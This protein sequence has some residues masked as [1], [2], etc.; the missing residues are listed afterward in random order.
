MFSK[1]FF[2]FLRGIKDR[3]CAINGNRLTISAQVYDNGSYFSL[4][5]FSP[6]RKERKCIYF[7][8]LES[9]SIA[10]F[11]MYIKIYGI[12]LKSKRNSFVHPFFV[13]LL[14]NTRFQFLP[15]LEKKVC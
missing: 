6:F 2:F 1:G 14:F 7:V 4:N 12:I 3:H 9:S 11:D 8:F 10:W 5:D 13:H 15:T